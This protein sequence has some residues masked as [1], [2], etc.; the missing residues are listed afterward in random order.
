MAI[1]SLSMPHSNF[2]LGTIIDPTEF[3]ENN[4]AIQSKVNELVDAANSGV[5]GGDGSNIYLPS[6]IKETYI[7]PVEIKSP[8]ITGNTLLGATGMVGMT[9]VGTETNAVRIWAGSSDKTVA[10]FRV[11]HDG[12]VTM[13]KATIE[14]AEDATGLYIKM[15]GSKIEGG[16]EGVPAHYTIGTASLVNGSRSGIFQSLTYLD[17]A[18]ASVADYTMQ[19]VH[20]SIMVKGGNLAIGGSGEDRAVIIGKRVMTSYQGMVVAS[21]TALYVDGNESVNGSLTVTSNLILTGDVYHNG[22]KVV[23]TYA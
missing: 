23:F 7:D 16:Y 5:T 1:L 4:A 18:N 14:T 8:L 19:L 11:L 15:S 13:T 21:G 22:K 12:S 10:P 20:N 6:Y 9:S 2:T 3:N 17:D